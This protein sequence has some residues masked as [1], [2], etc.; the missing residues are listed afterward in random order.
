M[1]LQPLILGL[2]VSTAC[3]GV[4][5]ISTDGSVL[6][7]GYVD[8][9]KVKGTSELGE[10]FEKLQKVTDRIASLPQLQGIVRVGI[11]APIYATGKSNATTVTKLIRFNTLVAEW[12][13]RNLHILP[14]LLPAH[15]ARVRSFPE[16]MDVRCAG[17]DG[18]AY[19]KSKVVQSLKKGNLVA[20]GAYPYDCD[21]K[22]VMMDLVESRYGRMFDRKDKRN[23]DAC[24]SLVVA[25]AVN[26][27]DQH[28]KVLSWRETPTG[29][30]YTV[31]AGTREIERS[32]TLCS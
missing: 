17:K 1:V 23:Y 18:K 16:L 10:L 11:E 9:S 31:Q 26:S 6:Y 2:D 28:P 27:I 5:V 30:E 29:L 15:E 21:R 8:L 32:V 22:E 14:T 20:F 3:T 7:C 24:D 25:L 4:S 12:C 13:W 19:Q